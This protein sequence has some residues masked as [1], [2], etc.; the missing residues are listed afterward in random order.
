MISK[1]FWGI[2][3]VIGFISLLLLG[4]AGTVRANE[5]TWDFILRPSDIVVGPTRKNLHPR[6]HWKWAFDQG[7]AFE[8]AVRKSAFPVPA[9]HCRMDY[10]ILSMPLYYPETP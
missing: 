10:L 7:G 1:I 2:C 3:R 5:L 9:P 6:R 8:V 4:M